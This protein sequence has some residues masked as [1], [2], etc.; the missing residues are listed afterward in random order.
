MS[1]QQ[2][3]LILKARWKVILAVFS[4]V[5]VTAVTLSLV[6][7]K[8]YLATTTV[9]VDVKSSDPIYG[10][11]M[12]S[13]MLPGYMATQVDVIT[14]DRVA[15]KVVR[16]LGLDKDPAAL[17]QWRTEASGEGNP[18]SFFADALQ[19]KLDVKPSKESS[20]ITIN[21]SGLDPRFAATVANAFAKAYID[22]DLELKVDPAKEY[23]SWFGA[24]TQ[25]L[26]NQLEVAQQKLSAFQREKGIVGNDDH[27][28]VE[29]ARLTELSTQLAIAQAQRA[30]SSSRQRQAS[31]NMETSADVLANPVIQALRA[32]VVRQEAKLKEMS[33]QL[34]ANHPQ[35]LRTQG[36]LEMLKSKLNSEMRQIASS[37]G[38]TS[39]ASSQ[40]EAE[41]RAALEAQKQRV[42]ASKAQHDQISV[43]QKDVE[44]AQ[45][46]Y[47]MVG[48]RLSQTRLE[49][50]TQQTNVSVLTA[51][52]PP[53]RHSSPK[54]LLNTVLAIFLGSLL[55]VAT[56]LM[57]ELS[58]RRI[59]SAEDLSEAL[60]VPVLAV[61]TR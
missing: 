1:F 47:D 5:V 13:Q 57:L 52:E 41:I 42:L 7:P 6:L 32:D 16:M 8:Q 55:G 48:Q 59:R 45:R 39:V 28:D 20:V 10:A 27:F 50:Q 61:L 35:Y 25:Q 51:A 17:E 4:G 54:L 31:G 38:S 30:D 23:A 2:F 19:K 29:N 12:Q 33:G 46:A 49:S 24:R 9:L 58:N 21:F 60:G 26:R 44:N 18:V 56:A 40:R 22:T 36:E 3:L 15:Q 11:F 34:G 37:V 53:V 14:S 43:L